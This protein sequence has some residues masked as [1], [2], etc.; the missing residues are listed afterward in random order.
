MANTPKEVIQSILNLPDDFISKL[1]KETCPVVRYPG[2][3]F[4]PAQGTPQ[5]VKYFRNFDFK[6]RDVKLGA[7]DVMG[8][9]Q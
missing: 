6:K 3:K 9:N 7:S 2:Y 8:Q 4:P 1:K 5:N